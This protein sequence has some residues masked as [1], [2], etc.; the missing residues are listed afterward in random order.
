MNRTKRA[1]ILIVEDNV[2]L[3]TCLEM[4]LEA[5]SYEVCRT[6]DGFGGLESIKLM[7]FDVIICDLMMP[8][9]TGGR[10][11]SAVRC[12]KPY[13]CDR[14]IFMSGH[15]EKLNSAEFASCTERPIFWKPFA[16]R[17]LLE[18]IDGV[19]QAKIGKK[20]IAGIT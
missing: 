7:D 20:E 3:A 11:H 8:G 9:M 15:P 14:F 18:A 5:H 19:V 10:L 6:T 1:S 13:L 4:L 12:L 17:D 2:P 16:M